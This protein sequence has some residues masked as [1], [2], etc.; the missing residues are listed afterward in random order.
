MFIYSIFMKYIFFISFFVLISNCS[1]N[2][3]DDHHGVFFLGKKEKKITVSE[4]N[5]NDIIS[6]FVNP[7]QKYIW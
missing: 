7:Q 1:F 3:V 4:S 5:V 6:I 2:L